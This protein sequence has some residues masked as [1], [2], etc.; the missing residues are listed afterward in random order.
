MENFKKYWLA[1]PILI[2]LALLG[3]QKCK[4]NKLNDQIQLQSVQ[5]A[6]QNDS[7]T[8]YRSKSGQ[9][10]S[11]VVS[12]LVEKDNAKEALE[13]AGIDY[14]T[15]DAKWRNIVFA[16]KGELQATGSG[17]TIL[18][19]TIWKNSVDT[20]YGSKFT[21]ANKFLTFNASIVKKDVSY[22]Y[23]YKTPIDLISEKKGNYYVVSAYLGDPFALITSANSITIVPKKVWR[24]WKWL[25]FGAGLGA[26]YLIFK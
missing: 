2:L 12:V 25:Q 22:N 18:R 23:L 11:K 9:L 20:V 3:L 26:G 14:K 24:G 17:T 8:Y 5:I 13:I 21:V 15:M 19:D 4:T 6:T 10:T 1:I 16:L 7:V